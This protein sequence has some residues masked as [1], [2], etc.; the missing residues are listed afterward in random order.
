MT[1]KLQLQTRHCPENSRT[2]L[3]YNPSTKFSLFEPVVSKF[4]FTDTTL[5]FSDI[6]PSV[7]N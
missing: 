6:I 7:H 4:V 2:Q 1:F 3:D 5:F